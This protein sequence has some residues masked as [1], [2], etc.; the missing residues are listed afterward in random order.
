MFGYHENAYN[1]EEG[2][3]STY[4]LQGVFEG[5]KSKHDQKKRKNSMKLGCHLPYGFCTTGSQPNTSMGKRPANNLH[6]GPIIKRVRSVA[7]RQ[8]FISPFNA[9]VAGG[10]QTLAKADASSGDTSSFQDDQSTLNGGSQIQKSVEVESAGD[11]EKQLPYDYAETSI[12]P[13]KKKIKHHMVCGDS[14]NLRDTVNLFLFLTELLV[15]FLAH[16][17]RVPIMSR[18]GSWIPLFIM[19]R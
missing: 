6:V 3:T 8:R 13:K 17:C 14:D 5:S 18:F 16:G 15:E 2:E 12:K 11:F 1:E 4:Y 10:L 7:Y 19:N 9:G